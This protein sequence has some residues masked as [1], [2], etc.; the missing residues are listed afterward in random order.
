MKIY[1]IKKFDIKAKENN[2]FVGIDFQE[3][4]FE[5]SFKNFSAKKAMGWDQLPNEIF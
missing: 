1:S 3:S 4:I 2:G 5:D